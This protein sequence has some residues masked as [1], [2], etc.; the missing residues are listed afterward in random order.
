MSSLDFIVDNVTRDNEVAQSSPSQNL[1][2][3]WAFEKYIQG[4]NDPDTKK[5]AGEEIKF[6]NLAKRILTSDGTG[7]DAEQKDSVSF[8]Q[9][10]YG[11]TIEGVL[12]LAKV[13]REQAKL[14]I[15]Q[16][17]IEHAIAGAQKTGKVVDLSGYELDANR[18]MGES[19]A[20]LI[21]HSK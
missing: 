17:R 5:I 4:I 3:M 21:K 19:S 13:L 8:L 15:G 2:M 11:M 1:T 18:I 10:K 7:M 6:Y 12:E 14:N 16:K 20:A 9:N